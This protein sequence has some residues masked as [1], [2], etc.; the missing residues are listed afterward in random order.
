MNLELTEK[1]QA[2]LVKV[3]SNK[4]KNKKNTAKTSH[5]ALITYPGGLTTFGSFKICSIRCGSKSAVDSSGLKRIEHL[6]GVQ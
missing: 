1:E 4:S 5:N 6:I 2:R 3:V